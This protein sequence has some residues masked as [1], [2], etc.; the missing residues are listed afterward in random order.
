MKQDMA[1]RKNLQEKCFQYKFK[2]P[3]IFTP[4]YTNITFI[5]FVVVGLVLNAE[6]VIILTKR[7]WLSI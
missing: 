6:S 1:K 2:R 7:A 3:K 5:W 4:L